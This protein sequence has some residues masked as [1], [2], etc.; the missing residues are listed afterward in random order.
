MILIKNNR[1]EFSAS[2]ALAVRQLARYFDVPYDDM[3]RRI[4]TPHPKEKK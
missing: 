4:K 3:V 1:V 2:L